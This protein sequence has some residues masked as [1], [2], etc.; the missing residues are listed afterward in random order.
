MLLIIYKSVYLVNRY[1]R[2]VF[3]TLFLC[4]S[5]SI[6]HVKL[7]V[8]PT[9]SDCQFSLV[10]ILMLL[11]WAHRVNNTIRY[12]AKLVLLVTAA[13]WLMERGS[14][15]LLLLEISHGCGVCISSIS[16]VHALFFRRHNNLEGRLILILLRLDS[17][18]AQE[19]L[20]GV[21]IWAVGLL[22]QN[23]SLLENLITLWCTSFVHL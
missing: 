16:N 4:T 19:A 5:L 23:I 10:L 1:V 7:V 13:F 2:S 3:A 15:Q 21:D 11:V 6:F 22:N 9:V 12:S 14:C 17:N 8:I 20:T 18:R